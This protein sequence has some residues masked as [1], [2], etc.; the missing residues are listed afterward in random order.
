MKKTTRR[1]ISSI[2]TLAIAMSFGT[3]NALEAYKAEEYEQ[4]VVKLN[5]ERIDELSDGGKIYI[6]CIDG[7][8]HKFPVPPEGFNPLAATDEQL[9]T[10]GFP[11]RPDEE[12][13]KDYEY[14]VEIMS[15]YKS[16]P[17]PEIEQVIGNNECEDSEIVPYSD[18]ISLLGAGYSAVTN[19]TSPFYTQV[20]GDFVQPT[21]TAVS[22]TCRNTFMVGLGPL[23]YQS[24]SPSVSAGTMCEGKGQAYAYYECFGTNNKSESLRI[25]SVPVNPGDKVHVY[26][27]YQKANNAFNYY[28]VNT[29]TGKQTSNTITYSDSSY[30]PGK[31]VSWYVGRQKKSDGT[32]YNLGKFTTVQFTNCQ[33]ML[34]TSTTWT[35]LGNLSWTSK[36]H[37]CNDTVS[38]PAA[39]PSNIINNNQF[40]CSWNAYN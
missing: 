17:V 30:Y 7:V 38:A 35:N 27:A 3:V 31:G 20:Q 29:T 19:S 37:M 33:A 14:W 4:T 9:N 16:T 40:N 13:S 2:T 32:L 24:F 28:I 21:I 22:G 8:E 23:Y 26:V 10:Y 1:V 15:S 5:Y 39:T 18:S 12:S 11:A 34:N 6:Y 36:Y 25:T